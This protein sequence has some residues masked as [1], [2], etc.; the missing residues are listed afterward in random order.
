MDDRMPVIIPVEQ[1]AR[2]CSAP[3]LTHAIYCSVSGRTQNKDSFAAP[4]TL[5]F[6]DFSHF[7]QCT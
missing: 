7:A 4:K 5:L 1:Y 2:A 6:N 3:S